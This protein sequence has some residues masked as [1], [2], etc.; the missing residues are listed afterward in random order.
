M[1]DSSQLQTL[2]RNPS[3]ATFSFPPHRRRPLRSRTY[4]TLIEILS[5][6]RTNFHQHQTQVDTGD[7]ESRRV[8]EENRSIACQEVNPIDVLVLIPS[9]EESKDPLAQGASVGKNKEHVGFKDGGFDGK[10]EALPDLDHT[11]LITDCVQEV[12]P[13]NRNNMGDFVVVENQTSDS[14]IWTT[15]D[16]DNGNSFRD[17]VTLEQLEVDQDFSIQDFSEVLDGCFGMDMAIESSK[18]GEDHQENVTME[19]NISKEAEHDLKLKEMELENLIY[20]SGVVESPCHINDDAEIEEGEISGEAGI[21]DASLDALSENAVSLGERT[22][23]MVHGSKDSFDKEEFICNYGDRKRGRHEM[24]DPLLVN[25]VSSDSNCREVESRT[26]AGKMQDCH[27]QSVFNDNNMKTQR[28]GSVTPSEN[29]TPCGRNVEENAA[30]NRTSAATEKDGSASKKKRKHGPL[31]KERRAKKKKKERIK[32]AE[33]NRKLGVKRL[34]LQPVLKPKTK[35]YCRHYLQGRCHEG[36]KCKFSHDTVPLT[37]SKPCGHFARHSCMKGDDCPFDHQLSKYP[38][39]N[40]ASNG[41][42]S[43]GSDC[44]FSHEIPAKQSFS[45][46][47]NVS[48]SELTSAHHIV[49]DKGGSVAISKMTKPEVKFPSPLNNSNSSKHTDTSGQKIDAKF[50]SVEDSSGKSAELLAPK[51]VPRPAGQAPK[52]VSFLLNG[53]MR[54]GDTSKHKQDGS[55]V[56]RSDGVDAASNTILKVPGSFNKTNEI[57]EGLAPRKPRGI[58][59]LSFAQPRADDSSSKAL[60]DFIANRKNETGKSVIDDM[61]KDKLTWSLPA[62]VRTLKVNQQMNQNANSLARGLPE[63][64]N[65]TPLGVHFDTAF[66][67]VKEGPSTPSMIQDSTKKRF[68]SFGGS[69]DRSTGG[70]NVDLFSPFKT[71]LLANSPSSVQKAVQSTLAFAAKFDPDV[72]IGSSLHQQGR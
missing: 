49:P 31:T 15:E 42:C 55:C 39:N 72:K 38:C 32:R 10:Q 65:G 14:A 25:L 70:E 59:F 57:F 47:P 35:A 4:C 69:W 20:N 62:S 2:T 1:D 58:N 19:E 3:E 66:S 56:K 52:G 33:K 41:F 29:P 11:R 24:S 12:I 67:L 43:R 63:E 46:A 36:D 9:S 23:E 51:P 8:S 71:S 45:M 21:A 30:E 17:I 68:L 5:H 40:Y 34:K 37:K 22:T 27:S 28:S 6:C 64:I 16:Q 26:S 44:L 50:C 48:K 53:G 13:E 18:V 7:V 61:V 54:L 60:P